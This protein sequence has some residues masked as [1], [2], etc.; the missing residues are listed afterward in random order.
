MKHFVG[1]FCL[2]VEKPKQRSLQ[3]NENCKFNNAG[4]FLKLFL[5]LYLKQ[6]GWKQKVL[7]RKERELEK[8]KSEISPEYRLQKEGRDMTE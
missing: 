7:R 8:W 1:F 3:Q 5:K 6:R 2:M 4:L